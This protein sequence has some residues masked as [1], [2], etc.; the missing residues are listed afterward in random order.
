MRWNHV[1]GLRR[2]LCLISQFHAV[3]LLCKAELFQRP[4]AV[5]VEIELV[6]GKP[7]PR[8][9]RMCVVIVVPALAKRKERNPPAVRR[10]VACLIAAR[11]PGMRRG[12]HQPGCVQAEYHAEEHS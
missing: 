10:K 12:I 8:G 7:V 2:L 6:P 5:P 3:D 9:Y 11:A 4:D 1:S